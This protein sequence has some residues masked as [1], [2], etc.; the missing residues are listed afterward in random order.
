MA[1]NETEWLVNG[2]Y[3]EIGVEIVAGGHSIAIVNRVQD[4]RL[5]SLKRSTG[6]STAENPSRQREIARLQESWREAEDRAR[7]M[8]CA[9]ELLAL[10]REAVPIVWG[11][12][13]TDLEAR[14]EAAIARATGQREPGA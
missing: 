7:L 4:K 12:R 1:T 14:M 3:G 10:V 11:V 8:S 6:A 13:N 5:A 9:P 2:R